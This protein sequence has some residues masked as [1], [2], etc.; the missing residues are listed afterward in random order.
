MIYPYPKNQE[1]IA[2]GERGLLDSLNERR[3]SFYRSCGQFPVSGQGW[4]RRSNDAY[5]F[6]ITLS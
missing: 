1:P 6:A 5:N 3:K 4:L 2:A